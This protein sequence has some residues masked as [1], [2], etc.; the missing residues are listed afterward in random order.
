LLVLKIRKRLIIIQIKL[1]FPS[2]A[3]KPPSSREAW[4]IA[5]RSRENIIVNLPGVPDWMLQGHHAASAMKEV[6]GKASDGRT[7]TTYA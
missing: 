3:S 7:S 2:G 1:V 4:W 6:A 5:C